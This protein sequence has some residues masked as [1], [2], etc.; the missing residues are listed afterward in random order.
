MLIPSA[1]TTQVVFLFAAFVIWRGVRKGAVDPPACLGRA[2]RTRRLVVSVSVAA[3]VMVWL[4]TLRAAHSVSTRKV[5]V[6][7]SESLELCPCQLCWTS[8][9][10]DRFCTLFVRWL[11]IKHRAALL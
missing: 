10:V 5:C 3:A 11:L 1:A 7:A 4:Q 6:R 9:D 8:T 2:S